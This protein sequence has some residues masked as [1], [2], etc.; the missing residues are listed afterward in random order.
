MPPDASSPS[1]IDNERL[2]GYRL[3]AFQMNHEISRRLRR[4]S[5][6]QSPPLP[7]SRWPWSDSSSCAI[8]S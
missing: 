3:A 2:M 8:V 6:A 4:F 5:P 7:S 1:E